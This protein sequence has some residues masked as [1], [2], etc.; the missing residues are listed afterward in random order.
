[1]KEWWLGDRREGPWGGG[2][3]WLEKWGQAPFV[4]SAATAP[5]DALSLSL[6][7]ESSVSV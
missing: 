5:V 6:S 7:D 1:M 3:S 2:E 4:V